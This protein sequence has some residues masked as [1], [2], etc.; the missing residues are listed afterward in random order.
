[1]PSINHAQEIFD[2]MCN[3]FLPDKA[4]GD[5]AMI[6]FDLS[7]AKGGRYWLRVTS[8]TC[9]IGNGDAPTSADMTL[10]A[11]GDDYINMITGELNPMQAFMMGKVKVKGNMGLAMKL[12]SWFARPE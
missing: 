3:M 7:G 8:G 6:Q 1:M 12:Q 9:E 4:Q 5:N 10:S 2:N 11:T